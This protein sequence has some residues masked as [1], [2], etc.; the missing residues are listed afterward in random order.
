MTHFDLGKL[1]KKLL[2]HIDLIFNTL[3]RSISL[4]C[5]TFSL[6]TDCEVASKSSILL[7]RLHKFWV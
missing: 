7:C 2:K 6:E 4:V 3:S 5:E 1:G